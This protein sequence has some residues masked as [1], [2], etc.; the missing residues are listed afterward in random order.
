M[1]GTEPSIRGILPGVGGCVG[2]WEVQ[3]RVVGDG[4]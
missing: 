2:A 1:R 4:R 3:I